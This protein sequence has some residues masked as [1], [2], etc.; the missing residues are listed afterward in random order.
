MMA[1]SLIA[2][3]GGLILLAFSADRFVDGAGELANALAVPPFLI[4]LT[5][6]AFGTSAPELV[7]SVRAVLEGT[8]G[9]A[10]GN[11]VGSNIANTFFVMGVL[12]LFVPFVTQRDGFGVD[13]GFMT[14][15]TFMFVLVIWDAKVSWVEAVG[16]LG[17][18]CLFLTACLRQTNIGAEL[19]FASTRRIRPVTLLVL[20]LSGIALICGASL[21]VWGGRGVAAELGV[22]PA[23]IGLTAV[24]LGTSLPELVSI[25]VAGL[26]GQTD[27]GIGAIISSNLFNL[28]AVGGVAGVTAGA[29]GLQHTK[30]TFPSIALL[31]ATCLV[32]LPAIIKG[33]LR[34]RRLI[35]VG[36]LGIY[37]GYITSVVWPAML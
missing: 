8:G 1:V 20:F 6:M 37:A 5:V 11:I 31:I 24:A 16:L 13:F 18:L 3:I 22:A 29:S 33:K 27:M 35:G 25:L 36:L 23:I 14:A 21:T 10:I 32:F 17:G 2:L 30:L 7:V 12:A 4:G 34:F 28:L 19:D 9:L 15:A 26:K